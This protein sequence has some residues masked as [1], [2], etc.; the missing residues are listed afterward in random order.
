MIEYKLNGEDLA[1]MQK[2]MAGEGGKALL[3]TVTDQIVLNSAI[4]PA[5]RAGAGLVLSFLR[6][7]SND[8]GIVRKELKP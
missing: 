6:S 1:K 2:A 5:D 4:T 3:D 8:T 7:L